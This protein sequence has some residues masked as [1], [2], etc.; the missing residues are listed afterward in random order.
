[1]PVGLLLI[2]EDAR[3]IAVKVAQQSL[4]ATSERRDGQSIHRSPHMTATVSRM[5]ETS[6]KDPVVTLRE[7]LTNGQSL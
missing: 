1:M 7:G 3:A 5:G 2:L 6:F 4:R